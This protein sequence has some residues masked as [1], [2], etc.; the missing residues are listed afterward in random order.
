MLLC[1]INY[2]TNFLATSQMHPPWESGFR[3]L[4]DK[5][6]GVP[7]VLTV[8]PLSWCRW[9]SA[10]AYLWVLLPRG[11]WGGWALKAGGWSR[12]LSPYS[13]LFWVV[14]VETYLNNFAAKLW[15]CNVIT[16]IY[17]CKRLL[18]MDMLVCDDVLKL[19]LVRCIIL[20]MFRT[21]LKDYRGYS[22]LIGWINGWW[23]G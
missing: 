9:T 3:P 7:F 1:K 13:V 21:H 14:S 10:G 18:C 11:R 15:T 4:L 22:P 2:L 19:C 17:L 23:P 16:W 8:L 5:P 6:C 20:G 12:A